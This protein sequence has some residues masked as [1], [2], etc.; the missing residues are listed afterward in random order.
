MEV[1]YERCAG[2]DVH[3]KTVVTCLM[4][5][6]K[7]ANG[8]TQLRK[9]VR[10]FSSMVKD[11]L[12]LS[13]WLKREECT[14]LV[15][16]STASYWKPVYNLLEGQ[17]ALIVVNA[18]HIKAVPGRKTDVKDAEW[19][20]ELLRHGLLKASF[21]PSAPQ[22]ELRELTRYRTSLVEERSRIVNRLQKV[23]EDTNIKLGSVVSNIM[24][25]SARA[26]LAALLE[27]ESNPQV[28]ADLAKGRLRE[29]RAE[30]VEALG[31][32]LKAHHR[33]MLSEQLSHIDYLDEAIE[34]LNR[35][36]EEQLGP[37][38]QALAH[39]DT[40]P[41][42]NQR[43]AQIILAEVGTD[44]DQFADA[45]H[46]A[47]WAGL[48]PGNKQSAGKRLS[49]KTRK[50][51]GALKRA[52]T[53]AAHAAG[54]TKN[55]FLGSQYRRLAG[56]RGKKVAVGAVAHSILVIVYHVL[57]RGEAYAELGANYY[58]ETEQPKVGLEKR[59][60]RQLEKLGYEVSLKKAS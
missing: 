54:H 16:E 26:M 41:G 23:L 13:D 33:F 50:G 31:G 21:I 58:L 12:A 47:S 3:K 9:E 56:R 42:V 6:D 15:M 55:T 18:Q 37:F 49:G 27:G 59:Y 53:E 4:V 22:R 10:T 39:L 44:M 38:E 17:F 11:L 60:I 28:L 2:L 29:K 32:E 24:G 20:A 43:I 1:L 7:L 30:L 34:R 46:L 25:Q 45:A 57:K 14:H 40:I 51:N 8:K 19:L 52:L 36:I 5:E 35:E 48:C